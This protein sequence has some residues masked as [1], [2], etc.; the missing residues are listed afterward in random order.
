M[1]GTDHVVHANSRWDLC[2]SRDQRLPA[3]RVL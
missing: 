1:K 2:W 3:G